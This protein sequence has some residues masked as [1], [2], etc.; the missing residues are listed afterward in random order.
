MHHQDA[1]PQQDGNERN[2]ELAF[3]VHRRP[4]V[5]GEGREKNSADATNLRPQPRSAVVESSRF[6]IRRFATTL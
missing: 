3:V 5:N 2:E 6:T 1:E 4:K